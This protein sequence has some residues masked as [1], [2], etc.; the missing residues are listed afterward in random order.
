MLDYTCQICGGP[1][2]QSERS[3]EGGRLACLACCV[4]DARKLIVATILDD[5]GFCD[6]HGDD[7]IRK[8]IEPLTDPPSPPPTPRE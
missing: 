2:E 4:I 5:D 6:L 7:V 8:A 3:L 1:T